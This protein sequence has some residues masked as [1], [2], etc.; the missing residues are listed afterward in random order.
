MTCMWINFNKNAVSIVQKT[1]F[2]INLKWNVLIHA[3]LIPMQNKINAYS[4]LLNVMDV[5]DQ[6]I[7]IV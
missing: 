7:K 6:G 1:N 4:V 3:L 5:E 2:M